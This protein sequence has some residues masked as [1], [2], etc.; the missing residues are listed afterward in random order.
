MLLTGTLA[1]TSMSSSRVFM[2][3]DVQPTK[4]YL[5]WYVFVYAVISIRLLMSHLMQLII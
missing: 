2:D 5:E 3:S 1:I 4:D